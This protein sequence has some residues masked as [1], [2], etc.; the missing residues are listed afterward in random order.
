[1]PGR[2]V[3]QQCTRLQTQHR[4]PRILCN[5]HTECPTDLQMNLIMHGVKRCRKPCGPSPPA[6]L[7]GILE[8]QQGKGP[9][10]RLA[11]DQ[12]VAVPVA[13]CWFRGPARSKISRGQRDSVHRVALTVRLDPF[14]VL[15][16]HGVYA[17]RATSAQFCGPSPTMATVEPQ[18]PLSKIFLSGLTSARRMM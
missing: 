14:V 5:V 3:Q 10:E 18:N 9:L 11:G 16:G 4:I 13:W 17:Q 8:D 6:I 1:M 2:H 7:I 15:Q 12:G